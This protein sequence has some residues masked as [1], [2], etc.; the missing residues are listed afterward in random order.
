MEKE[1]H[2]EFSHDSLAIALKIRDEFYHPPIPDDIP[3]WLQELLEQCWDPVPE[4]RPLM[5]DITDVMRTRLPS[6]TPRK[7]IEAS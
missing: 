6:N 3:E 7:A 4:N 5:E 2:E 1:P